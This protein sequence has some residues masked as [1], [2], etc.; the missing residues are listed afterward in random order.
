MKLK[1]FRA[2]LIFLLCVYALCGAVRL[3]AGAA[4][5]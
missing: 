3:P 2:A 1:K 4:P 5:E